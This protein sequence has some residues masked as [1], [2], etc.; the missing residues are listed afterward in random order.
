MHGNNLASQKHFFQMHSI[1]L[2]RQ[3]FITGSQQYVVFTQQVD[4][5]GLQHPHPDIL[6]YYY[7]IIV[8]NKFYQLVKK[9]I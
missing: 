4:L 1:S 5:A 7:I 9:F 6:L 8:S 2:A 3:S